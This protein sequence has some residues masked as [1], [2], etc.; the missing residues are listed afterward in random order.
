M[1]KAKDESRV[2]P[3]Y[4]YI[5]VLRGVFSNL[6]PTN[7]FPINLCCCHFILFEIDY[8]PPN[9]T[10]FSLRQ[11]A[12]LSIYLFLYLSLFLSSSLSVCRPL[13]LSLSLPLFAFPSVCLS[14]C[15]S[16]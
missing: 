9:T 2:G 1:Y 4:H 5:I 14:L 3:P 15:I 6:Q 8:Q 12:P 10:C 16:V 11:S 13:S 7:E